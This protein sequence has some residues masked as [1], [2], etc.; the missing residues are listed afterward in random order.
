MN[1]K[2]FDLEAALSGQPFTNEQGWEVEDW[3]YF[4]GTILN[5]HITKLKVAGTPRP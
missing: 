4:K 2:P 5:R 1:K 3:H